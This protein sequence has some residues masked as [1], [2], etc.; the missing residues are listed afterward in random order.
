MKM[1]SIFSTTAVFVSIAMGAVQA[2]ETMGMQG[3]MPNGM[4]SVM[5]TEMEEELTFGE[6]AMSSAVDRTITVTLE[7]IAYDLKN[8]DIKNGE[9]I[10]FIIVNKDEIEHEFTLGTAENQ[11][12]D[13]AKMAQQAEM[14]MSMEMSE[15]N[16]V[17]V[18][19]LQTKELIWTFKGP[20]KIEFSCNVP[21]HY[22]AGMKGDIII[23]N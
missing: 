16:S 11:A 23:R 13:R 15:P 12:A 6:P 9:T 2:A 7:D 20:E 18:G 17:S 8:L 21:G 19:E 22:E 4:Q 5:E 14:G 3:N 10:R 1:I